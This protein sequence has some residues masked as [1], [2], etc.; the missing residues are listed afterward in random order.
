MYHVPVL[1]A[2]PL[3]DD[4]AGQQNH[5]W[6][7]LAFAEAR[8]CDVNGSDTCDPSLAADGGPK[9]VAFRHSD[10]APGQRTA[11]WT[12]A[13]GTT[14]RFLHR[15]SADSCCTNLGAAVFDNAT[16]TVFLHLVQ[17]FHQHSGE[18]VLL[19]SSDRGLSWSKAPHYA[20]Q[21]KAAGM[22]SSSG[23]PGFAP[24]PG[25]G[26]QL[27]APTKARHRMIVC[28]QGGPH[29]ASVCIASNDHGKSKIVM[30]SRSVCCLFH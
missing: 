26:I 14:P 21:L 13:L 11:S 7:M 18:Q 25:L 10:W 4:A 29:M 23:G 15:D 22:Y 27:Q 20:A 3:A 12:P 8:E 30:L 19:T 2:V 17:G 9:G 6:R 1:I 16:G 28:G 5:D 24:G